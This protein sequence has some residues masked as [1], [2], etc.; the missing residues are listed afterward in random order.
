MRLL[1]SGSAS[2]SSPSMGKRELN[3]AS[4]RCC[5]LG[6]DRRERCAGWTSIV[7]RILYH[8]LVTHPS[9]LYLRRQ[10]MRRK[11]SRVE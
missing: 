4:E 9:M 6:K 8:L 2:K 11:I 1:S 3:G 10:T 7:L 5:R